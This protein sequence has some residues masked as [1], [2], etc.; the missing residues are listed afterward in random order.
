MYVYIV[1]S[2]IYNIVESVESVERKITP[3]ETSKSLSGRH[4]KRCKR[5]PAA[6][7]STEMIEIG[8]Y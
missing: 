4:K 5:F 8:I 2:L 1:N 6:A 3:Y 7:P